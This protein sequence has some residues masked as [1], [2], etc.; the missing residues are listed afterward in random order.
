VDRVPGRL[1]DQEVREKR[2]A[3]TA[4][5]RSRLTTRVITAADPI[6]DDLRTALTKINNAGAH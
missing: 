2:P 1:V 6:P 3:V 4:L 5:S